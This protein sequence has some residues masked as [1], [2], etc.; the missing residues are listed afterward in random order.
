MQKSFT[1]D[2]KEILLKLKNSYN[3]TFP[4]LMHI[5][6]KKIVHKNGIIKLN[7]REIMVIKLFIQDNYPLLYFNEIVI[8]NEN[9]YQIC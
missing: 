4:F 1:H 2:E 5:K 7:W 3:L 9:C 6:A 8:Y